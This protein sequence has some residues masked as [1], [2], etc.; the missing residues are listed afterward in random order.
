MLTMF[1]TL[2]HYDTQLQHLQKE[3]RLVQEEYADWEK[4]GNGSS[5]DQL[6]V[7]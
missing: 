2:A 7:R 6:R 3:L 5:L 1:Q 4:V